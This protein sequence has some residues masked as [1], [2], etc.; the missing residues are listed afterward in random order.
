MAVARLLRTR[1]SM[2]RAVR[3]LR[4]AASLPDPENSSR[5]RDRTRIVARRL[6]RKGTPRRR[7]RAIRWRRAT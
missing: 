3:V 6:Q 1:V 2:R 5:P 4:A 7:A